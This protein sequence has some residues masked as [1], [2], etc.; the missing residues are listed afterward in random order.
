LLLKECGNADM[1]EEFVQL[2]LGDGCDG[3]AV[4]FLRL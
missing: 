2:L 1:K 3:E 4:D